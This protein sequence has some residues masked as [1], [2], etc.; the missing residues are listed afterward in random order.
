MED[1]FVLDDQLRA[2]FAACSVST[3]VTALTIF[4]ELFYTEFTEVHDQIFE[5]IDS[6]KRYIAIAAPRGLGKTTIARTVASRFILF[7]LTNFVCYVMNSATVAEMQTENLKRDLLTN[8]VVRQFFGNIKTDISN[9]IGMDEFSKLAWTAF[10]ETLVLPRGAGQQVRGL[11]WNNH[12]PGLIIV[13]DLENAKELQNPENRTAIK[14]WFHSDLMKSVDKYKNDSIVIY[15]DTLKHE[16]SLLAELLDDPNWASIKLSLAHFDSDGRIVS[17]IPTYM[18]DAEL[19]REYD[20]HVRRGDLDTFF[21]EYMNEPTSLTDA[22]FSAENF[23]HYN[24]SDAEFIRIRKDIETVLIVDPAKT[25]KMQAADS[26]MLAIGLDIPGCRFF[27]RNP[28]SDKVYPDQLYDV[29]FEQV[30]TFN[31]HTV[32]IEVTSLHEFIVQPIKNEMARRGIYFNLIELK[33]QGKKEE[34][35]R[36]IVPYYRQGYIY[37][38]EGACGKLEQQLLSFPKS[39]LWDLMDCLGY[40]PKML[41]VGGRYFNP[42]ADPDDP[43]A[44]FAELEASYDEPLQNWRVC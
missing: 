17:N 20:A 38:R 6:G 26:A 41:E 42:G 40:L 39:R 25:V 4:P 14:K 7:R 37:H 43:D 13:D 35:I 21:S 11:N 23:K 27:I 12:R 22:S 18:S 44:E 15:I 24:E 29:I 33:A 32:G 5:L 31:I 3:K 28:F 1:G 10:G 30:L 36:E 16:D 19:K 9:D 2:I 34:R 8:P